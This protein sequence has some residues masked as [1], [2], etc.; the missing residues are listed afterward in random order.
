MNNQIKNASVVACVGLMVALSASATG[1]RT[2]YT[3][4]LLRTNDGWWRFYRQ[5]EGTPLS[6]Y[7][8]S[9]TKDGDVIVLFNFF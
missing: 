1:E 3:S 5:P 6:K 7:E 9:L 2:F 4:D 8:M